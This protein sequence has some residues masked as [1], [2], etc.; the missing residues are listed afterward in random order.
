[1]INMAGI[2]AKYLA[3]SFAIENVVRQPRVIRSCFPISMTSN[4]FLITNDSQLKQEAF[5]A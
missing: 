3:T 5:L 4:I 1:M 2:I